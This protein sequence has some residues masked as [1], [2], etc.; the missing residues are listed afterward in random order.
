MAS[1]FVKDQHAFSKELDPTAT[2]GWLGHTRE[3][4]KRFLQRVHN[5]W[6]FVGAT[7]ELDETYFRKKMSVCVSR[8]KFLLNEKIRQGVPK[9]PEVK[10]QLWDKLTNLESDPY[11]KEK[12]QQMASITQGRPAKDGASMKLHKS[13]VHNLVSSLYI[14]QIYL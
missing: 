4:K 10:Q 8:A 2:L 5:A 3:A 14:A 7:T 6:E 1:M 12:S 13:A 9:P 11:V